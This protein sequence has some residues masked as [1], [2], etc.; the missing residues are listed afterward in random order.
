M[1]NSSNSVPQLLATPEGTNFHIQSGDYFA[2]LAT[3]MGF[4]EEA[5]TKCEQVCQS[6]SERQLAHELRQDLRF[7]HANYKIVPRDFS[8][9][10]P[11]RPSGNVLENIS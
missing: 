3:I 4:L 5:S 11:V 6:E 2:F 1:S 10:Q 8:E 7:V 9:I